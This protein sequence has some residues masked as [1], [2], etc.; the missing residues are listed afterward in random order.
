MYH[1]HRQSLPWDKC[2]PERLMPIGGLYS[3]GELDHNLENS[4]VPPE[5]ICPITLEVMVEPVLLIGDGH[6]YDRGSISRWLQGGKMRSP[7]TNLPL[8]TPQIVT[9]YVVRAMLERIASEHPQKIESR[10]KEPLV[11]PTRPLATLEIE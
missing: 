5:L 7:V 1:N 4:Q 6:T 8:D 10:L 11:I 9:N 3:T 2:G